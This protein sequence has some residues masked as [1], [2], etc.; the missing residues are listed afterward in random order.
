[1]N[2]TNSSQAG[3]IAELRDAAQRLVADRTD[4][5]RTRHL[6]RTLPGHDTVLADTFAELGWFAILVPEADGGIGLGLSEMA[7]LLRELEKGLMAEPLLTQ[8]VLAAR[9]LV[10]AP[11][12]L[13]RSALLAGVATGLVRPILALDFDAAVP[14]VE[15]V[16]TADG[17]RL[18]GHVLSAAGAGGATHLLVPTRLNE[19]IALFALPV[20]APGLSL[21]WLWRADDS[22]LGQAS[23]MDVLLPTDGLLTLDAEPLLDRAQDETRIVAAGALLGLAEHMLA[24]TIDYMGIRKQYDQPIGAFQALQHKIVDLYIEKERAI[25]ALAY[26][27][28]HGDDP[29]T[30]PLAALRA[31]G[32]CSEAASRIAREA[33]QLHGAIG[34]TQEHDLGLYVKRALTLSAWLGNAGEQRR[35]FVSMGLALA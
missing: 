5:H 6:R 1:M 17:F 20:E 8:A 9:V 32:R 25:A 2:D 28:T 3:L 7:A 26:G 12:G 23:L 29:A 16:A 33:I 35:R 24:M 11:A 34:F 21:S 14:A 10:Q 4:H 15:A 27:L 13:T 18:S 22:P 30:L 31:K 19:R